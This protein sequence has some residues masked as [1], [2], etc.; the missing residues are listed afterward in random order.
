MAL[1]EGQ[2]SIILAEAKGGWLQRNWRPMLMV[3]AILIIFNNYV[4]FPYLSAW[5]NAVTVLEL[6]KGLW[7]LLNIGVGGYIGART[8]EKIKGAANTVL[9]KAPF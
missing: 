2:V 9:P 4:V 7:A 1:I 5:T 6:P 8:V 3:I